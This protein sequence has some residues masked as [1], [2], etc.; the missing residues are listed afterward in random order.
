MKYPTIL[1]CV[2]AV[3]VLC[4]AGIFAQTDKFAKYHDEISEMS[5]EQNINSPELPTKYSDAAREVMLSLS[6]QLQKANVAVDLSERGGLVLMATVPA[7]GLFAANDTALLASADALLK[8][9]SQ[10]LRVPDRFKLII[11]VHSDDTGSE[12]YLTFLT[13]TR[14]EAIVQWLDDHGM[15]T[16]GVVAYGLGNDE[17]IA[18]DSSRAGRQQN[19]RIEFY[20]VPGPILIQELKAK[21]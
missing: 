2:L 3:L 21:K 6:N 19:R 11:A 15:P 8:A 20:Y 10:P 1:R 17:P 18:P 7:A 14:A 13:Q 5:I 16:L 9:V 4:P 12:D